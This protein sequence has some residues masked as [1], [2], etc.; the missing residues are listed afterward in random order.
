LRLIKGDLLRA[1]RRNKGL[2]TKDVA[3]SADLHGS[4]LYKL[5]VGAHVAKDRTAE[6]L[7]Y[8]LG[9][10]MDTF[11][12]H[13]APKRADA[14]KFADVLGVSRIRVY[15]YLH[16]GRVSGAHQDENGNWYIPDNARILP[17]VKT[18]A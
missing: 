13:V 14:R 15:Q 8:A 5:E 12:D 17:K 10:D 7:A 9:V 6:D 11:S 18:S 3:Y 1:V 4:Y 2:S 16:E